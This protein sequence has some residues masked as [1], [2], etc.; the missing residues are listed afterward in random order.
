MAT[1]AQ[2]AARNKWNKENRKT[3][4]VGFCPSDA[5]LL[6]WLDKQPQRG[7]YIRSLIRDDMEK[8]QK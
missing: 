7:A 2:K 3:V 5:D 8:N 4:S 6:E 1:D